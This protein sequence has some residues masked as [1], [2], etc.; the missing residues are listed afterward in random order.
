MLRYHWSG[1]LFLALLEAGVRAEVSAPLVGLTAPKDSC[2]P[3]GLIG[4]GT[5]QGQVEWKD[6]RLEGEP[7]TMD[8]QWPL[9]PQGRSQPRCICT[10]A[11]AGG[12]QAF[13]DVARLRNGDLLCVFYAGYGHVSHPNKALPNG[14]RVCGLRSTDRGATWSEPFVIADTPF[15]DRDPSV[16]QLSDGTVICNFFTYYHGGPKQ[17]EG[18]AVHYKEIWLVRST[19]GGHT[20]TEPALIES[21]ANDHWACSSPIR[22]RPDGTL[23]L[24]IY[25][26]YPEPLRNWSAMIFSSDGGQTRS[27]PAWVDEEN[28]DND[29]PDVVALPDGRWLCVM[30]TNRGDSMWE[31]VSRDG[32]QTW[33]R[34]EKI[35]FYGQA[36]YLLYTSQGILLCAHRGPG[37]SLHYSLDLG[38]TWSEN[39]LLDTC[40]GAY[41]SLV[42]LPNGRVLCVYYEEGPNS[43]LRAVTFRATREGIEFEAP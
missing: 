25:R 12:Y 16:A 19:D 36:P 34:A 43:A 26:E 29:E 9:M 31:S 20:W 38:Q 5:S 15:D 39:V 23:L 42:E 13:P 28:D 33:S 17:R 24:P 27:A 21:T 35:G 37:T 3:A 4:L 2:Y 22:E 18:N 8:P 30:R 10:D 6:F 11:G 32:G 41:P 40:G 14:G 7:M 1:F